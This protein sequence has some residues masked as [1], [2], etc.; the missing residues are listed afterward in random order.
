V[1]RR[2]VPLCGLSAVLFALAGC[3]AG[4]VSKADL[5]TAAENLLE[6]QVGQRPDVTCPDDLEAEVG[7]TMRCTLTAEGLDGR[8]GVTVTVTKVDGDQARFD[9]QVDTEPLG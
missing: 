7:A 9:V 3:G 2:L 5:A 8:Y 6:K 4:T 1:P